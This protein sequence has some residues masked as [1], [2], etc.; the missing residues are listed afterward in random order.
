MAEISLNAGDIY[1]I[2]L[3]NGKRF[4]G[5]FLHGVQKTGMAPMLFFAAFDLDNGEL[6]SLYISE[7]NLLPDLIVPV[8][9]KLLDKAK[10][11]RGIYLSALVSIVEACEKEAANDGC[12]DNN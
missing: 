4:L 8:E 6:R 9:R 1:F 3:K 7:G 11:V 5:E 12:D 10:K 2:K